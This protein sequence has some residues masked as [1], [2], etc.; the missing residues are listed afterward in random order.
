METTR[1]AGLL[2]AVARESSTTDVEVLSSAEM[3]RT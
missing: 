1:V 2:Y 3:N